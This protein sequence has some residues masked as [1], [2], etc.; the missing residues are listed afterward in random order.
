MM[1]RLSKRILQKAIKKITGLD[2]EEAG[3]NPLVTFT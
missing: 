1:S 3:K 2:D